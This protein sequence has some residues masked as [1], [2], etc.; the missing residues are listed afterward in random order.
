MI[1]QRLVGS[2][3]QEYTVGVLGTESGEILGS[4]S[5]RR[6]LKDGITG[7]AEVVDDPEIRSYS[8]SICRILRPRGYCNV[9]L[10]LDAG[11]PYAFE[12]NGRVSS[13]THFRALANF[14]EPEILIRHHLLNET[15]PPYE[16]TPVRI[17]RSHEEIVVNDSLWDRLHNPH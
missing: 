15:I 16:P 10:R 12:I 1:A 4:I 9:Q 7:A 6:Y 8:E 14:N 13:S 11:K 3:D 2:D 5:L 17:I